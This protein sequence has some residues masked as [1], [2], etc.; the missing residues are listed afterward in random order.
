MNGL[1]MEKDAIHL[2]KSNVKKLND[3]EKF[4]IQKEH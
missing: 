1:I 3:L 4:I 2:F